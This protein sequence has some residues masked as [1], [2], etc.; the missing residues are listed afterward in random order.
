[1]IFS[2]VRFAFLAA[3]VAA[4]FA[5]PIL[6]QQTGTGSVLSGT[7]APSVNLHPPM[8]EKLVFKAHGKGAQIYTCSSSADSYTWT[9]KGPDAKL[10]DAG[11][12]EIGTHSAGPTW[13]LEDGSSIKGKAIAN[14]KSAYPD[15]VPWLLLAVQSHAGEG[16][17]TAIDYVQR[18][19]TH[20]GAAPATGCDAGHAGAETSVPYS[21][22]YSFYGKN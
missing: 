15:A 19:N 16:K 3:L 6:S 20:G 14:R 10:L 18:T 5:A 17:L 8:G 9:L 21:A 7:L 12:H 11:G 13:T 1:M 2:P 22:T 4:T